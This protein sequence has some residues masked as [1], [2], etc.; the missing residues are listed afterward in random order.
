MSDTHTTEFRFTPYKM[1]EGEEYMSEAQLQHFRQI[2]LQWKNNLMAEVDKTVQHMQNDFVNFSD[3][4]DRATLEEEV[5]MELRTRERERKLI[6][7]IE[8]AITTIDNG[9]YGFC[10]SCDAEIGIHRLEAR[11]TAIKCIDCKTQDE[12]REKNHLLR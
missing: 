3:P 5:T 9:E 2:L 7:K 12:I 11:P 4:N 6:Q 1:S 10:V 8:K